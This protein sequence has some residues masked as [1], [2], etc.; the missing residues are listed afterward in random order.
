MP[1]V[2]TTKKDRLAAIGQ[3]FDE[4]RPEVADALLRML[5]GAAR[6]DRLNLS[7]L[8]YGEPTAEDRALLGDGRWWAYAR[9]MLTLNV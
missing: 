1:P 4:G 6:Q 3:L 7:W 2:R 9:Y 5:V 8:A